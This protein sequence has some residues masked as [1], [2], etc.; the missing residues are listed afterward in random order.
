MKHTQWFCVN[1][2][3]CCV[4]VSNHAFYRNF[5]CILHWIFDWIFYSWF[6][7]DKNVIKRSTLNATHVRHNRE[8]IIFNSDSPSRGPRLSKVFTFW[9]SLIPFERWALFPPLPPVPVFSLFW[10]LLFEAD[11]LFSFSAVLLLLLFTLVDFVWPMF[12]LITCPTAGVVF[13]PVAAAVTAVGA[14][15]CFF[16]FNCSNGSCSSSSR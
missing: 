10:L 14:L 12:V 4:C 2:I 7:G 16:C 8:K 1:F 15:F 13:L 3:F 9:V 5:G 11:I 6:L